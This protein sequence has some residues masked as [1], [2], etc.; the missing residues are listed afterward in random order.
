MALS[1][2]GGRPRRFGDCSCSLGCSRFCPASLDGEVG[3]TLSGV[4]ASCWAAAFS[5]AFFSA[6]ISEKLKT[7]TLAAFCSL[8]ASAPFSV[9]AGAACSGAGALSGETA[10]GAGCSC[11]GAGAPPP[12]SGCTGAGPA[13]DPV[14]SVT[15]FVFSSAIRITS[16]LFDGMKKGPDRFQSSP[17]DRDTSFPCP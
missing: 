8:G 1:S 11:L 5:A 7:D 12:A 3:A 9:W 16:F 14:A 4:F 2:L 13:S 6:I 15:T 10:S 17:T